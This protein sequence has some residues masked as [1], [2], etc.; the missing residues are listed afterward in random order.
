MPPVVGVTCEVPD[1]AVV[2][3]RD[4]DVLTEHIRNDSIPPRRRLS[5]IMLF[6]IVAAIVCGEPRGATTTPYPLLPKPL[7]SG[8]L[9]SETVNCDKPENILNV[10]FSALPS[11]I[12]VTCPISLCTA[13]CLGRRSYKGL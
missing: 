12:V 10:E 5:L 9:D 8:I 11:M 6:W 3:Y 1:Y 2:A 4:F 13:M 7:P